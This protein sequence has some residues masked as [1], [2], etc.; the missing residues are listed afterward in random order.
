[1]YH[2]LLIITFSSKINPFLMK[3]IF[4]KML[5]FDDNVPFIKIDFHK[6]MLFFHFYIF[7]QI[8]QSVVQVTEYLLILWG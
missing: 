3:T 4:N 7:A 1:M 5:H 8:D 2:L 6:V